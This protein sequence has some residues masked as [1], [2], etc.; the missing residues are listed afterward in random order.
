MIFPLTISAL[1]VL[2]YSLTC[3]RW[4]LCRLHRIAH[5]CAK[6]RGKHAQYESMQAAP[7]IS[8]CRHTD[9]P[10]NDCQIFGLRDSLDKAMSKF[11]RCCPKSTSANQASACHFLCQ[12]TTFSLTTMIFM[13]PHHALHVPELLYLILDDLD[14]NEGSLFA[15]A[16]SCKLFSAPALAIIWRH[17]S[18][19]S[20]LFQVIPSFVFDKS[21]KSF[22]RLVL[23]YI[24]DLT[25]I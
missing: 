5:Y 1:Q 13:P 14:E 24:G 9:L 4:Q 21:K 11:K 3:F 8:I 2:I 12:H 25:L 19:I 6:L 10:H 15:M 22:V 16:R 17:C 20:R 18:L 7:Q 23:F